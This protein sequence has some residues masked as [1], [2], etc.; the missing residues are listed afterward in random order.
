[1]NQSS[2]QSSHNLEDIFFEQPLGSLSK[3]ELELKLLRFIAD[4]RGQE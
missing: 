4:E 2:E 3:R 1:M